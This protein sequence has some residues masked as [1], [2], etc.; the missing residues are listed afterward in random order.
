M[1]EADEVKEVEEVKEHPAFELV[2]FPIS[3]L[4][5]EDP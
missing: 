5:I 2:Q 4:P 3:R 1:Q